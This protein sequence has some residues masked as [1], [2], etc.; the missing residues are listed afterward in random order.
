VYM[1][2]LTYMHAYT[3]LHTYMH[4]YTDL[5]TYMYMHIKCT[6]THTSYLYIRSIIYMHKCTIAHA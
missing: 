2:M 5:H 6:V 3:D 4:K 1:Y